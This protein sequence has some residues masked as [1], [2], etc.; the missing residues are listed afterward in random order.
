M[1]RFLID[2]NLWSNHTYFVGLALLLLSLTESERS[3]SVR[4]VREGRPERQV[5]AWPLVL[6]QLQLSIVYFYSAMAKMNPTFLGGE[7]LSTRLSVPGVVDSPFVIKLASVATIGLELFLSFAL[8]IPSLRYWGFLAGA[9]FH[10][11]I[12][13]SIHLYAALVAFS[14]ATLSPYILFLDDRPGSRVVIWD[15]HCGFCRSWVRLF[16][17]FD[18]LRIHRFEGAS[19]DVLAQAGITREQADEEVKVWDGARV[20]GGIDA[21]REI[22]K[23]V[24]IGFLWAQALAL[25]GVRWIGRQAYRAVAR[26]RMCLTVGTRSRA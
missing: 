19:S 15:D 7:I 20:Y 17:R 2:Q 21:V 9:V 6:L 22:L 14:I 13:L 3:L 8:W 23:Y 12:P 10:A 25:P 18:W 11:L 26:R 16:R 24:P 1:L 4:W 5:T